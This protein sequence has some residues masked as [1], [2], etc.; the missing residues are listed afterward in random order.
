MFTGIIE[1][2]GEISSIV[3]KSRSSSLA[4][5]CSKIKKGLQVGDSV[6]VDGICLTVVS[7]N[8]QEVRFDISS[9]TLA[10][11]TAR[12]YR[13]KTKANLE[14]AARLGDRIGGHLVS[15]HIDGVGKITGRKK[16]GNGV[17]LEVEIPKGLN[18]YLLEKGSIAIDGISLTI[19]EYRGIKVVAAL[20]PHTLN[21]TTLQFK[22]IGA[23]VN[24][25]CDQL[26]KY[27]EK[28]STKTN[29]RVK[30]QMGDMIPI[31]GE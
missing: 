9:E 23:L 10:K 27:V 8:Q 26:G 17:N 30:A 13:K 7:I 22:R 12:H 29:S 1:E 3:K 16:V 28:F 5:K 6:A 14:R 25:E 18:R 4:L 19:A 31:Y 11:S 24:I 21:S 15:G 20:I 2:I